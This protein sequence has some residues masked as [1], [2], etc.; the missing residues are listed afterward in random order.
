MKRFNR[1]IAILLIVFVMCPFFLTGCGISGTTG[2][3]GGGTTGGSSGSG[4]GTTGGDTTEDFNPDEYAYLDFEDCISGIRATYYNNNIDY[5]SEEFSKIVD[6]VKSKVE[7]LSSDILTKLYHLYYV[8]STSVNEDN[9]QFLNGLDSKLNPNFSESP[10]QTI[11][12]ADDLIKYIEIK[13]PSI[14]ITT[15][16]SL[17]GQ[18]IEG[19]TYYYWA[20]AEE[21]TI[22]AGQALKFNINEDNFTIS[23]ADSQQI[24][25]ETKDYSYSWA[26]PT[27]KTTLWNWGNNTTNTSLI[28]RFVERYRGNL[29]IA[30]LQIMAGKTSDY[31]DIYSESDGKVINYSDYA[32]SYASKITEYVKQL[33]YYGIITRD[34]NVYNTIQMET[35]AKFVLNDIIG[36]TNIENDQNLIYTY[37]EAENTFK[38]GSINSSYLGY[39]LNK[40]NGNTLALNGEDYNKTI[41]QEN[42]I[43]FDEIVFQKIQGNME[44]VENDNYIKNLFY[45][46]TVIDNVNGNDLAEEYV[47]T[48][49]YGYNAESNEKEFYAIS[50]GFKNYVNS[51]KTIVASACNSTQTDEN[52]N[53]V[54]IYEPVPTK[55]Y[56]TN[57]NGVTVGPSMSADFGSDSESEDIENEEQEVNNEA[58]N[59]LKIGQQNYKSLVIYPG[60]GENKEFY[61]TFAY[62]I[63]ESTLGCADGID[64]YVR[65]HKENVGFMNFIDDKGV[66]SNMYL[67]KSNLVLPALMFEDTSGEYDPEKPQ[68]EE[69]EIDFQ[70]ILSSVTE[71]GYEKVDDWKLKAG[72]VTDMEAFF[73]NG[74]NCGKKTA[75]T[76]EN[77]CY[78][79]RQVTHSNGQNI[80]I[81]SY[82][83]L[84]EEYLEIVFATSSQNPFN[85]A[86]YLTEMLKTTKNK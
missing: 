32:D 28:D 1:L 35:I 81:V 59:F 3:S 41:K 8:E 37:N 38:N 31:K 63:F 23:Y 86:F 66:V 18:F 26:N 68:L 34:G 13:N 6:A 33:S 21:K 10:I 60:K 5:S 62:L 44:T 56:Y 24:Q 84:K 72:S 79:V 73:K 61:F 75:Y 4:G 39:T 14:K 12:T 57:Y 47:T 48:N 9:S 74:E 15:D 53:V 55:L 16:E 78:K 11:I 83:N 76:G 50:V 65:Y 42:L 2:S 70:K 19:K 54:Y 80:E 85:V 40:M 58:P 17:K 27:D 52:D 51:V 25:T 71:N 43:G 20:N 7:A 45:G 49:L 30:I 46:L 67:A 36:A 77:V 82:D 64:V 29:S 69:L 22:G